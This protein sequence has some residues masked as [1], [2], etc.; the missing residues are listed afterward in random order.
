[1]SERIDVRAG[2]TFVGAAGRSRG[3]DPQGRP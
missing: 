1:M 2:L 3:V